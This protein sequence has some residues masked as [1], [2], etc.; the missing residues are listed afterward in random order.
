M[1]IGGAWKVAL[2]LLVVAVVSFIFGY[3]AMLRFLG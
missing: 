3:Y 2:L 1:R